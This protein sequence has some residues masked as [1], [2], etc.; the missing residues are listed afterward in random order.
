MSDASSKRADRIDRVGHADHEGRENHIGQVSWNPALAI[1]IVLVLFLIP[2]IIA[3][4]IVGAVAHGKAAALSSSVFNQFLFIFLAE[5]M[6][7]LGLFFILRLKGQSFRSLGLGKPKP[8]D[9]LYVLIGFAAYFVLNIILV[10]IL[11]HAIPGLNIDQKQDIGFNTAR[12]LR[13]LIP[14]FVALVML[15]PLAE[16]ILVRGFLFGS[17]RRHMSLVWALITTS[18]IFGSAHLFGGEPGA[19]LLWIA[20]IDTFALSVVLC[21]LREKTGHLWAGIG[22]HAL[23]NLVAFV[24]LFILHLSS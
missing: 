20:A 19:P 17:L 14:V 22:L 1:F 2:Q 10:S 18:V 13:S 7:L 15:A 24:A 23:K 3:G 6:T 4:V 5:A 12:S 9:S 11:S 16:E 21:Y 8:R